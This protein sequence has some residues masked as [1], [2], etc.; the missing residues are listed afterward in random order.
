VKAL[1]EEFPVTKLCQVL[2][3]ARST[4]LYKAAT[5]KAEDLLGLKALIQVELAANKG[6]GFVR[7]YHHLRRLS[8]VVSRS[9]MRRAYKELGLLKRQRSRKVRTT[10]SSPNQ[11]KFPNLVWSVQAEF[12]NHIGVADVTGIRIAK[13]FAYLALVMDVFTRRIVGWAISLSNDTALT[14]RALRMG[15]DLGASPHIHHSDQGANY[16]SDAYVN[17]LRARGVTMSM[18]GAGKAYENGFAE[19]LNRTVKE[20][21]IFPEGYSDLQSARESIAPFTQRYNNH[22]IHSS[23]AWNTPSEVFHHWVKSHS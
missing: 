21:A 17:L 14:L 6:Y 22:R 20:E 19:R 7:M 1:A 23:L 3:V 9:Q 5:A 10:Y 4:V 11:P 8:V 15:L 18:A 16:A 12:P 13:G 2:C